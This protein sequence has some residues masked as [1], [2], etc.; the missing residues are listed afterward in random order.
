MEVQVMHALA[1]L[2]ADVGNNTVALQPQ[3]LCQLGYD[4][5]DMRHHGAVFGADLRHGADMLLGDHQKMGGRL[6]RNVIKGIAQVVLLHLVGGDL[7]RRNGAEQAV[8]LH[9][10]CS[11]QIN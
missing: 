4:L 3:F 1:G 8:V 6:R 7:P 5:K 10:I 9:G 2:L 11:F